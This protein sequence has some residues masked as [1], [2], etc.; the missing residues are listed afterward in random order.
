M[1]ESAKMQTHRHQ[2]PKMSGFGYCIHR[3]WKRKQ[4]VLCPAAPAA[5]QQTL[6]LGAS[7]RARPRPSAALAKEHPDEHT[8]G[9]S[10]LLPARLCGWAGG[11]R[12][13]RTSRTKLKKRRRGV[14]LR[15][16]LPLFRRSTRATL[17]PRLSKT[18][19]Q[20]PRSEG[21]RTRALGP[22]WPP[23]RRPRCTCGGH[24]IATIR[25]HL[26]RHQHGLCTRSCSTAALS[27]R[28][29]HREDEG[30]PAQRAQ[31]LQSQKMCRPPVVTTS[32]SGAGRG[33]QAARPSARHP[34]TRYGA[35]RTG[36]RRGLQI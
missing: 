30:G 20:K 29:C 25:L 16:K 17:G 10:Q 6:W 3:H 24:G 34:G 1:Q 8:K 13:H 36:G 28:G 21:A 18:R 33:V 12:Y 23:C 15:G 19:D 31:K 9:G 5:P 22:N 27:L 4:G 11:G 32:G 14:A 2:T 7:H 35:H 26:S